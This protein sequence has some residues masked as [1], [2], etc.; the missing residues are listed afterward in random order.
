MFGW[1]HG[2][3]KGKGV[4]VWMV[5]VSYSQS[6]MT[7]DFMEHYSGKLIVLVLIS[8][9]V[10]LGGII[11]VCFGVDVCFTPIPGAG[12]QVVCGQAFIEQELK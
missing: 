6:L 12:V 9:C 4:V 2:W 5:M 3:V 1:W 10:R 7:L 8:Q 11:G